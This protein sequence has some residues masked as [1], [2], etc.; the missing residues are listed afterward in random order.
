MFHRIIGK[1]LL[2][3]AAITAMFAS[4]GCV[5]DHDSD[6]PCGTHNIMFTSATDDPESTRGAAADKGGIIESGSNIP[7]S[8]Q[9]GIYA[10]SKISGVV[11]AFD[12]AAGRQSLQNTAVT[13]NGTVISPDFRY[14]PTAIWPQG[15]GDRLA[16]YG[17]YPHNGTNFGAG[18]PGIAVTMG[19]P[20][21]PSMSIAYT[22]PTD[23]AKQVDL[24]WAY[25]DFMEAAPVNITFKHAMTRVAFKA[26]KEAELTDAVVITGIT[27]KNVTTTGTLSWSSATNA[28]WSNLG[29]ATSNISLTSSNGLTGTALTTSMVSQLSA[30]AK[31]MMLIPQGLTGIVVEVSAT[32]GGESKTYTFDLTDSDAHTWVAGGVINYL[33]TV[34]DDEIVVL[35]TVIAVTPETISL[36]YTASNS[37]VSVSS[38]DGE[39]TER[40]D[41]TWTLTTS[42]TWLTLS[43]NAD[44]TGA[45]Q[46]VSGTGSKTVYVF[47]SDNSYNYSP[48]RVAYISLDE[49]TNIVTTVTQAKDLIARRFAK[50][51]A[52]MYKTGTTKIV[53]FAENTT[54]NTTAKTVTPTDGGSYSV[55]AIPAN[56]QGMYFRW[57]GLVGAVFNGTDYDYPSSMVVNDPDCAVRFWPQQYYDGPYW[58]KEEGYAGV[59]EWSWSGVGS[60]SALEN[61]CP[62]LFE[63]HWGKVKATDVFLGFPNRTGPGYDTELGIGDICR[64]I[65]YMDWVDD[66]W[67]LPTQAEYNILIAETESLPKFGDFVSSNYETITNTGVGGKYGYHPMK[68]YW[69]VGG[70]AT[71]E[72]T[73]NNITAAS[74]VLP[75]SGW[76]SQ[77]NASLQR[78]GY[79]V[80]Y[81]G[82]DIDY[83][84]GLTGVTLLIRNST[85]GLIR[86][87]ERHRGVGCPVRCIRKVPTEP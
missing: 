35:P 24:M 48:P 16:F 37:S 46:T 80:Y 45:S 73:I 68:N 22:C 63:E 33:I 3:V 72:S 42:E 76:L 50:S 8:G 58:P 74:F 10:Y 47:A 67:R 20:A 26:G 53:T 7:N 75:I 87:D 86:A 78:P 85:S 65:T 12:N 69:I 1:R 29:A 13:N 55:P 81:M 14:S 64:Y 51:N 6:L 79:E 17:Y 23:P 18:G 71:E 30:T 61:D 32:V 52:I 60:S 62:Y 2:T 31:D 21:S 44:G 34:K 82:C 36:P 4:A 70:E 9:F 11:A 77:T 38:T 19:A 57:G 56:A 49:A 15:A 27:L 39:G 43:L 5:L 84:G 83:V 41:V 59:I 54:E 40:D 28:A 66:D 25:T